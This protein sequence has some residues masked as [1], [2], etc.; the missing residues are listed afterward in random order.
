MQVAEAKKA[1]ATLA[2]QVQR[3]QGEAEA[4]R[5]AAQAR[6]SQLQAKL[7]RLLEVRYLL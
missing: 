2:E 7:N 3:L 5:K 6:E 1:Q 4:E